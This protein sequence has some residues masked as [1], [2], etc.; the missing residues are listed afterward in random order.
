MAFAVLQTQSPTSAMRLIVPFI[1]AASLLALMLA[2]AL[3]MLRTSGVQWS[4]VHWRLGIAARCSRAGAPRHANFDV[5]SIRFLFQNSFPVA[6]TQGTPR[7]M[8]MDSLKA[9]H[10]LYLRIEAVR[11]ID[12]LRPAP[13]RHS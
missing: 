4:R 2:P 5:A 10:A 6:S 12:L 1:A 11:S 13:A 3:S 9:L 8:G 7:N